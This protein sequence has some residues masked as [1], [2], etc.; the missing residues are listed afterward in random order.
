MGPGLRG[1]ASRAVAWFWAC[2]AL[3]GSWGGGVAMAQVS[4]P[5]G[6][7]DG[8]GLSWTTGGS[9]NWTSDTATRVDG[10][11]SGRSGA[12]GDGASTWLRTT[13]TGPTR[14]TF[15]WKVSSE[16]RW[17]Y[18]VLRVGGVE[19]SRI[20]GEQDWAEV[21][22]EVAASG[23]Q[24]VEF[25][26]EKDA[27]VS[28]G[29]DAGWVDG[30]T[31]TPATFP[32][33]V[34][35]TGGIAW[36]TGGNGTWTSDAA[37]KVNGVSSG[38][39]AVIGHSQSTWVRT[40]VSGPV[41]L[42][43]K[44]KVSS[45]EN[46][47]FLVLRVGGVD[48]A[49][50]SGS[51]D[52]ADFEY[53]VVAS[54]PWTVEF[55]YT[56]NA[57]LVAG[58]DAG[59]VDAFRT[60]AL[61]TLPDASLA[62]NGFAGLPYVAQPG[63]GAAWR[64][65]TATSLDGFALRSGAINHYGISA[66]EITGVPGGQTVSWQA[67]VS[68]QPTSDSLR[69]YV[70]GVEVTGLRMSGSVEWTQR[71]HLLSSGL[72]TLRWA[73]TKDGGITSGADAAWL[74]SLSFIYPPV[75]AAPPS[76]VTVSQGSTVTLE[77]EGGGGPGTT[78]TWRRG[79]T[80]VAN[81]GRVSGADGLRL[82]IANAQPSD[83][84]SYTVQLSNSAGSV[85]S[86]AAQVVVT[87]PPSITSISP[88]TTLN[89]GQPLQLS[90]SASGT[91]PL[92]YQWR[93]NGIDIAGATGATYSLA[94]VGQADAGTYTVRVSNVAGVAISAGL[95][96]VV[97]GAPIITRNP[98]GRTAATGQT[99]LLS[100]AS[101]SSLQPISY[102]W[103]KDGT[104]LANDSRI[105]GAQ[106]AELSIAALGA[107]D[108]GN[109]SV[110]V[111]NPAGSVTSVNA[112]VTVVPFNNAPTLNALG[113]LARLE[114][115]SASSVALSG[116]SDGNG[117]TQTLT[118]TATSSDT[119]LIPTPI[120][121]YASPDAAGTLLVSSVAGRSGT[122]TVTVRGQDDGGTVDGGLNFVEQQFL[123]TVMPVNDAPTL[124]APSNVT[125]SDLGT[126]LPGAANPTPRTVSLTGISDGDGGGQSLT[127]TATS[128]NAAV[129]GHPAVLYDGG[130]TATLSL[131]VPVLHSD[132]TVPVTVRVQ[133]NGG[134]A[135]GGVDFIERTFD[136]QVVAINDA[137]TLN[138]LTDRAVA[139][140]VGPQAVA[141]SGI[142]DGDAGNQDLTVTATSSATGIV[143]H[144]TVTYAGGATG[145]LVFTPV[146]GARGSAT[147]TVTVRDNA[148]T[149]NGGADM[150]TRS[151]VVRVGPV[152]PT[153][154]VAPLSQVAWLGQPVTFSVSA[155]GLG[156]TYKWFKD[157]VE[158]PGA[159]GTSYTLASVASG[160]AATYR[161][162][163]FNSNTDHVYP[164]ADAGLAVVQPPAR[165]AVKPTQ[166]AVFVTETWAPS[167]A[168]V[169][170]QWLKD[171]VA[172]SGATGGSLTIP[173]VTTEH[174]GEY[175]L[176]V[177]MGSAQRDTAPVTLRLTS[178]IPTLFSTGVDGQ[179]HRLSD[180]A[181]DA[182]YS[183]VAPSPILGRPV[184]VV[185]PGRFPTPPWVAGGSNSAWISPSARL[186][187]A[188]SSA[189][190][191]YVYRTTFDLA[192]M[193]LNGV[194]VAGR[195]AADDR[196]VEVRLN[197]VVLPTW[198]S[199]AV[200]NAYTSFDLRLPNV[201]GGD[202]FVDAGA[203]P[204]VAR[205]RA[206]GSNVG[207]TPEP[208]DPAASGATSNLWN[209]V[210]WTWT[211]PQSGEVAVDTVGSSFDT[212][213][214][215]YVG[216]ALDGLAQIGSDN[217]GAANQRS[218][219]TF[220]AQAGVE[221][222]IR[223]DGAEDLVGSIMLNIAPTSGSGTVPVAGPSLV[224]G[225]NTLD[226]VVRNTA[227]AGTDR[228][229]T[230][231]RVEF[232]ETECVALPVSLASMPVGGMEAF[233]NRKV[234]AVSASSGL[235]V[236]YQWYKD[237]AAIPGAD[238][239]TLVFNRVEDL[240]AGSYKVRVE[241]LNGVM[242]SAPVGFL[243]DVPLTITTQPSSVA[244]A[245]GASASLTVRF[246]GN[247]PVAVQWL[248]N[249]DPISEA[250]S[251][252]LVIPA[253]TVADAGRYRAVV[254]DRD[255]ALESA[256]AIVEV[257][258]PP[259]IVQQ[260]Q[261]MAGV[262]RVAVLR[263]ESIVDG[264]RPMAFRWFKD[265][266]PLAVESTNVLNLGLL[267]E[268][269]AGGYHV[270]A[271]NV[272]GAVTSR[273]A[274][275]TVHQP[276]SVV[277]GSGDVKAYEGADARFDVNASGSGLLRYEW[278]LGGARVPGADGSTLTLTNLSRITAGEVAVV[279]R[280][281]HG[282]ATNRFRLDVFPPPVPVVSTGHDL[283]QELPLR[284]GWNAIFLDVQPEENRVGNVFTN[285]PYTS[286]WRWS[287]PGTG[288][289]FI[290]D[291]SEAQ[292]DTTRWQVHLP[293]SNPAG[294]QNNLVRVY[295]HEAYLVH[296]GGAQG[297]TVSVRGKPGYPRPRWAPDGHSLT[298]FPVDVPMADP[299]N[300]SRMLPGVTVGE[301]LGA[302]SAHFDAAT[303][304]PRGMY[305]LEAS[306]AWTPMS[307]TNELRRGVA[308]WVYTRGASQFL[309]PVEASFQG[310]NEL[311]YPVGS[312]TKE[313]E[314]RFTGSSNT[315]AS[316]SSAVLGHVLGNQSL[317]LRFNEFS[318]QDGTTWRDL[319]NGF[320]VSPQGGLARRTVRLAAARERIPGLAYQG[321]MTLRGAGA[322]HYVPVTMDRDE[323]DVGAVQDQPFN[324]VGLWLGTVS[325]THV[326][327][328]NGLTTNYVVATVTNVVNGV[329]NRVEHASTEVRNVVVGSRPT[330]VRDPF[331]LR[332]LLHVDTQGVCRLLEQVT[333]LSTP[334]A[335]GSDD[336][337]GDPVLLTGAAGF[338]RYRGVALRGRD[339]VGR[340]YS[341][342]F[343]PM[344]K[345]N[346]IPFDA[347]LS[348]GGTLQAS[349]SLPADAAVNPFKHRYHPD[350]DNL[351]ASFRVYR[352][353]GYALRRTVKLTVPERQA[354]NIRAGVGQDD[355]EGLYEEVVQGVHR[356]PMT[357]RGAFQIK[358]IL[359]VGA[360][361]PANP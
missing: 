87:V 28:A 73:Y 344:W 211:A 197:G 338:S 138:A 319:P 170:R 307:A 328:V 131:P 312:D 20:T 24:V 177:T 85:T 127:L 76:S 38:R 44:W 115:A 100:V 30:F 22:Q 63:S 41:R 230:G 271:E 104:D 288:P 26:Y 237:D 259:L 232:T 332:I 119:S 148:G 275:V 5:S 234:F 6:V 118:V 3:L 43:F 261:D 356:T 27:S 40:T 223:V 74:D 224:P 82:V 270:V 343:F 265:G 83:A 72:H 1:M 251:T 287:D 175:A 212:L 107:S 29:V 226:F 355:I 282:S 204:S 144:P 321:I 96:V 176:R 243:V 228:S 299:E 196:L 293:P 157:G 158:I 165:V 163:V 220:M 8:Q 236:S 52:W 245:V 301:F 75:L 80:A 70:D 264:S 68:S 92:S 263:M 331:D 229:L 325:I 216:G 11:S 295:R 149:A 33:G 133:D 55:A 314:L 280:S 21:Q 281:D 308:Y 341:T 297:V 184:A 62:A 292:L 122:A 10:A 310:L 347:P 353:E 61:V 296:L 134:T 250:T 208:G 39:S 169:T 81:G 242:W 254:R 172:V 324:P 198:P 302:S 60:T 159:T 252:N 339:L 330:S 103:Q 199:D 94:A 51:R 182:H 111:A 91:T 2:G 120:V 215:V 240:D 110:V 239:A 35:D 179:G 71:S 37:N 9:A 222:A 116:I 269:Q 19:V 69:F 15:R 59:W 327:E 42:N 348:L 201:R 337:G 136:V 135:N 166:Q 352:N 218:R 322:L 95:E 46:S 145:S 152:P 217:D 181:E 219:V 174:V 142:S 117:G 84:G 93:R 357:V 213:L 53:D 132:A 178:S 329:T 188:G 205:V 326:S 194:R 354:S 77:S 276:P 200:S 64:I 146:L 207:A 361:D 25:S 300:P 283:V 284:P 206:E 90:L 98:E 202:R 311:R 306:G 97:L 12:I 78:V 139:D 153:I 333:L 260:P 238:E 246:R 185:S 274:S 255:G 209:T 289:Q 49:R 129:L 31:A 313:L 99:L 256:D 160:D 258:E 113:A 253:V 210:W 268:S 13:V 351:D 315:P 150:V 123:V 4:F 247:P 34:I 294:F 88:G 186:R 225:T 231:L 50:V 285:V 23:A 128:G 183:L 266:V 167:G 221:Y 124:S 156:M 105:T 291:Q 109:Y 303:G 126:A 106:S 155:T 233:G 45:Q 16:A 192:G 358:R 360:L 66:I 227:D 277:S 101:I 137:P 7:L 272:V 121:Q 141:L 345:T 58:S 180:R 290:S 320:P 235:P 279:V 189:G 267:R 317:P 48:V 47:D 305:Q 257:V 286:I 342:P 346:G 249:D 143:G 86:A 318:P 359:A 340:R 191:D 151:F 57:S 350:H 67:R 54:G 114:D 171:G 89:P 162:Q 309:A 349:W 298:G 130:A 140:T 262:D 304:M 244:V 164:T 65:D 335:L 248:R 147:L 32:S 193:E 14:L 195:V 18:L 102:Q 17:D 108:G 112:V 56:K 241:N 36:Q 125:I 168:T 154:D 214:W 316:R 336:P 203:L 273:V 334:P 79:S 190:A 278:F 323:A 187:E 173:T 161:V